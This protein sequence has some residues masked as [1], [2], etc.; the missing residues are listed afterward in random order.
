[1]RRKR[2]RA[3][4]AAT[5]ACRNQ[6]NSAN[7]TNSSRAPSRSQKPPDDTFVTSTAEVRRPG[8]ADLLLMSPC[9]PKGDRHPGCGHAPVVGQ[10]DPG[11]KPDL[12]FARRMLHMHVRPH[13]FPREEVETVTAHPENGRAHMGL[14][15]SPL[16]RGECNQRDLGDFEASR[17]AAARAVQKAPALLTKCSAC[18]SFPGAEPIATAPRMSR[19]CRSLADTPGRRW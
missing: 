3:A 8:R 15:L 10:F 9:Q 4:I 7:G 6:G 18:W 12:R 16:V 11:V 13:L 17:A 1:M 5:V 2:Q 14:R 19:R